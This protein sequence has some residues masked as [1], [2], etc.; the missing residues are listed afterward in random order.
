MLCSWNQ[1]T[2]PEPACSKVKQPSKADDLLLVLLVLLVQAEAAEGLPLLQ[3]A[4]PPWVG[5][6]AEQLP[7]VALYPSP[8]STAEQH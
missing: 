4:Q 7:L 6:A 3:A 1:K 2:V 8:A 5:A